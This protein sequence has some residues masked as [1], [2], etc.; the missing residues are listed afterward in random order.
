MPFCFSWFSVSF[1]CIILRDPLL[2]VRESD[3]TVSAHGAS[4][5]DVAIPG[6]YIVLF[7]WVRSFFFRKELVLSWLGA[8]WKQRW[9]PQFK[10][11]VY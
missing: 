5:E 9:N 4:V 3:K 8:L 6:I 11:P 10:Y 2:C 1:S 7:V